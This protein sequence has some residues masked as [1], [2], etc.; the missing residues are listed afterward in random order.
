MRCSRNG[1]AVQEQIMG[2]PPSRS[3]RLHGKFRNPRPEEIVCH[4]S[5]I[6]TE[7]GDRNDVGSRNPRIVRRKIQRK[8]LQGRFRIEP[9]TARQD[10]TGIPVIPRVFSC[11][12]RLTIMNSAP[13]TGFVQ[14]AQ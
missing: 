8:A 7:I 1:S 9:A 2:F 14:S 3:C 13:G 11:N 10:P 12:S 4:H 6:G 5:N